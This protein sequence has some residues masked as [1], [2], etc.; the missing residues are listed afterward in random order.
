LT[1]EEMTV[2]ESEA[3]SLE[4]L[5]GAL[6]LDF[7]NTVGNHKTG[8]PSEHLGGY[9]DWVAWSQHAG[10]L[11]PAQ[12]RRLLADSARHP[13]EARQAFKRATQLREAIYRTFAA[14]AENAAPKPADLD[15]LNQALA[16]G[17]VHAR[18]VKTPDGFQ[19][20]WTEEDALDRME[21]LVARS[22]ADLLTSGNLDRVRQCGDAECGW[23]FVDTSRNRSRRWCDMNDCGN[24]AKARRHYRRLRGIE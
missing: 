9:A 7:A 13:M 16:R 6:C 10:A 11:T 2:E 18:V 17:L 5:G 20:D 3:A 21:W 4:L 12:A 22:A 8:E 15:R 14:I 24:R 19:W 1:V 23:L